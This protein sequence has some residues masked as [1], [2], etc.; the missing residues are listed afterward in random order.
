MKAK[1]IQPVVGLTRGIVEVV[2]LLHA[3]S[4]THTRASQEPGEDISRDVQREN[5]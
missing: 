1:R 3:I 2:D 4:T 5:Q